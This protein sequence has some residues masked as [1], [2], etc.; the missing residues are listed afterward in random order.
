MSRTLA[1]YLGTR[2]RGLDGQARCSS[3]S[4]STS[5][6]TRRHESATTPAS[7]RRSPTIEE[8]RGRG[9]RARPGLA[10]RP[11]RGPREPDLSLAPV[12]GRLARADRTPGHARPGRRR[13]RGRALSRAARR[14]RDPAAR[15]RPL[16]AGGDQERPRAGRERWPSSPTST[17]T[18]PSAPPTA[19][20]PRTEGVAHLL[21]ERRRRLLEREVTHARASILEKPARP[22]VAV[23]RR[24]QGGRQDRA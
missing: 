23:A 13:R 12:A 22:L 14:G 21:P 2:T 10:P 19:R 8:L 5:R 1:G 7:G 4:T 16:R 18:T 6:S 15:E 3:G 20:T 9:A 24:R 11:P 17:S